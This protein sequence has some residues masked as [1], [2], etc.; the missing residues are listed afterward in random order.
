MGDSN[1]RGRKRHRAQRRAKRG[2]QS[3]S[4]LTLLADTLSIEKPLDSL[5]NFEMCRC[6]DEAGRSGAT[7]WVGLESTI[8]WLLFLTVGEAS[9]HS[10]SPFRSD[11][12]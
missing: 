11:F 2:H 10:F 9:S 4:R 6:T 1:K 12:L 8:M 5:H 7:K 3:H